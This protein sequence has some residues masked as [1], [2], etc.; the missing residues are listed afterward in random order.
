MPDTSQLPSRRTWLLRALQVTVPATF[1]A[2]FY[3]VAW[4]LKPRKATEVG[5]DV[6]APFSYNELKTATAAGQGKP[7]F[8]AWGKPC[9]VI[10]TPDGDVRAF[11]AVCTHV[12]CT[13]EFRPTAGDI[14]CNCHNGHYD[15]NGHNIEG[16]PPRPLQV[17]KVTRREKPG[18]PGQE[19]IVVSRTT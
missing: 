11:N 13:V 15:L 5:G 6:V 19:E 7:P 16:P 2:L 1:A 3:P 9:L 10:C 4:F 14:F 17:Y 12:E 18:Q 8:D